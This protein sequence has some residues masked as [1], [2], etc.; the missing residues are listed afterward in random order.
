MRIVTINGVKL[1][2]PTS[3]G[4]SMQDLDSEDTTRNERGYL[5]RDRVRAGVYKLELQ[6]NAKKGSEIQI[7]ESTL[8]NSK[9]TVTFPDTSGMVTKQMYVGDRTKDIVLYK[10]GKVDEVRWNLNF[11]LVEY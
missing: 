1:P 5:Q 10:G 4:V 3:L 11:N 9:L 7:I 8:R 2:P 6:F